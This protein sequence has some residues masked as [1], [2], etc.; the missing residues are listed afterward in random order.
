[1]VME[2][3]STELNGERISLSK[4]DKSLKKKSKE[5]KGRGYYQPL[6]DEGYPMIVK[7]R[8]VRKQKSYES[9]LEDE[10]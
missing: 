1:M 4:K 8:E 7:S 10:D 5:V 2:A 6:D 3:M 9:L